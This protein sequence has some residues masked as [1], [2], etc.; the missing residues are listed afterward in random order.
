M[1]PADRIRR[2]LVWLALAAALTATALAEALHTS[3]LAQGAEAIYSDLWHRQAGVRFEPRATALVL[4][5]ERSLLARPDEPLAFWSPH[6]ARA[7]QTLREVGVRLV[8]LDLIFSF[9]PERWLER[10]G[11][12]SSAAARD[13]D[14]ALR[15]QIHTGGVLLA[16][17]A[18]GPSQRPEDFLLPHPDYLLALPGLDLVAHLG[19]ANLQADPDGVVRHLAISAASVAGAAAE[20]MPRYTIAGLAAARAVGLELGQDRQGQGLDFGTGRLQL[21]E[22]LRVSFTGPPGSYRALSFATLLQPGA[23]ALP[24]VRALAGKVVVLGAGYAGDN[25]VHATPYSTGL[26]GGQGLMGGPELQANMIETL[27]SG[28]RFRELSAPG[29]LA[30]FAAVFGLLALLAVRLSAWRSLLLLGA[31][32]PAASVLGYG[33]FLS[34]WLLPVAHLQLGMAA[35]LGLLLPMRLTRAER[36]RR[37]VGKMFARYVSPQVVDQLLASERLPELGGQT[38]EV[39]VLFMDIRNFTTLSERLPAPEV[40][41]LLNRFFERACAELLRQGATIDKFIGDAVMAEFGAPLDQPD[42]AARALR[43]AVALQRVA[44]EFGDWMRQRFAGIELPTFV[45]GVGLHSGE[46]VVG[47][48]GAST[49]MEYTAIG[50]TVN[51]ASRLEGQTKETGCTIL[52]SAATV[53]AAGGSAVT[54][55]QLVLQ[56]KGH[57]RPVEA[58]EI[59]DAS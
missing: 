15:E 46:A 13:F 55:R 28:K 50:D 44:S 42:H 6:F 18:L 57:A 49:R 27:L 22:R 43:A 5:D 24:E 52:A 16:A 2:K 21:D 58:F 48:M 51:L 3:G 41:E 4:V 54:G 47:N 8:A 40:V 26:T 12:G 11:L 14:R 37:R 45:V 20:G 35:T 38:R 23:A 39:T 33:M 31:G 59:L 34:D 36:E 17:Y 19:L 53:A 10:Q 1:K 30:T 7:L 9:S 29:R 56:V 25:D 32:L